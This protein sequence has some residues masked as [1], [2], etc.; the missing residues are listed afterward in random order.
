MFGTISF[1]MGFALMV[2]AF[3]LSRLTALSWSPYA[4]SLDEW[5]VA[6]VAEKVASGGDYDA[7]VLPEDRPAA[8]QI[9]SWIAAILIPLGFTSLSAAKFASLLFAI[10]AF[11]A[12]GLGVRATS[13]ETAAYLAML[14]YLG[15]S[16]G[17]VVRNLDSTGFAVID[18]LAFAAFFLF[19]HFH[20]T[21]ANPRMFAIPGVL[22]GIG[23]ASHLIFICG[24]LV[25]A[26]SIWIARRKQTALI[27][28]A[29]V[30]F[31]F[32]GMI[33]GAIPFVLRGQFAGVYSA[34]PAVESAG[35]DYVLDVILGILN[36]VASDFPAW[37][38]FPDSV[39]P[40]E[41]G[42]YL[43]YAMIVGAVV[44]G[45]FRKFGSTD[46][47]PG[48]SAAWVL[49][50]VASLATLLIFV[51][52]PWETTFNSSFGAFD[53]ASGPRGLALIPLFMVA[54]AMSLAG[55]SA[56][57]G[58]L[59][60]AILLIVVIGTIGFA[61]LFHSDE[62]LRVVQNQPG[63]WTK[64]FNLEE[65]AN[66]DPTRQ[67]LDLRLKDE[68]PDDRLLA[69]FR[70]GR[71]VARSLGES[72][73]Q[74]HAECSAVLAS[75]RLKPRERELF[76]IGVGFELLSEYRQDP[77]RAANGFF[78]LDL[79]PADASAFVFGLETAAKLEG[80]ENVLSGDFGKI[81]APIMIEGTVDDEVRRIVSD[82]LRDL[83]PGMAKLLLR[84]ANVL[85][86]LERGIPRLRELS[87]EKVEF[88]SEIMLGADDLPHFQPLSYSGD[89]RLEM[90]VSAPSAESL[91]V[92]FGS[93]VQHDGHARV[94]FIDFRN[95]VAGLRRREAWQDD[96][97]NVKQ[98]GHG[99][100]YNA[101]DFR[102]DIVYENEELWVYI[103]GTRIFWDVQR[104]HWYGEIGFASR[105]NLV[106]R[107][108]TLTKS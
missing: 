106:L 53:F 29:E 39:V 98:L 40:A 77:M 76:A 13:G 7:K 35:L 74:G 66:I 44:F 61:N 83:G 85:R 16:P 93:S 105:G 78:F 3:V 104:P 82:A 103:D 11:V 4:F 94:L 87:L 92:I 102:L 24:V 58:A 37:L 15:A 19:L 81:F 59:R 18:A 21:G 73:R 57:P 20:R 63:L 25:F 65:I 33:A 99:L 97:V 56:R 107:G 32:P 55:L 68:T 90:R 79:R 86:P 84:P 52:G 22:C 10:C 89:F 67:R 64:L 100:E 28:A 30:K 101:A 17:I 69:Y 31:F 41:L 71:N 50:A 12:I 95:K 45:V 75:R 26:I 1:R 8:S 96:F 34:G 2:S 88:A 91:T 108:T 47:Q 46:P 9:V 54:S 38:I 51:L 43:V 5:S 49:L 36:F 80:V 14:F 72:L 70:I 23:L 62:N 6:G 48:A 27:G 42:A 60:A